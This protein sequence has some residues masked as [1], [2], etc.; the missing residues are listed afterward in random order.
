MIRNYFVIQ[1]VIL[2]G[3]PDKANTIGN[4]WSRPLMKMRCVMQLSKSNKKGE[5]AP[6]FTLKDE[7]GREVRLEDFAGSWLLMVFHR[8]LA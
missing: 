4:A 1:T 6:S 3:F 2:S 5:L 7:N 8:H